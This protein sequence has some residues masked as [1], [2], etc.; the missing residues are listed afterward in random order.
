MVAEEDEECALR[1]EGRITIRPSQIRPLDN[2]RNLSRERGRF[3]PYREVRMDDDRC[4]ED[5]TVNVTVTG[6]KSVLKTLI[7]KKGETIGQI[8]RE[9]AAAVKV[10]GHT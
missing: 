10:E 8:R 9:C 2:G 1:L 7:G 4:L 6:K 3:S 5:T